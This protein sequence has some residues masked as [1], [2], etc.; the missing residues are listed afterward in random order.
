LAA[1]VTVLP[2]ATE[3]PETV[4]VLSAVKS[5]AL[6]D[7]VSD[8]GNKSGADGVVGGVVSMLTGRLGPG[9][10]TFP[11]GSVTVASID[12]SPSD[13]VGRSQ[14]FAVADATYVHDTVVPS[15]FLAVIFTVS[16]S[17]TVPPDTAGVLS[18]VR[19]SA[20]DDPE[21]DAGNKSGVDGVAGGVVSTEM[22]RPAEGDFT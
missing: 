16:P 11:A 1:I 12:Q 3:P 22:F 15:A 5:S 8:A 21:S 2:F 9:F 20:S 18:D 4:G 6:E 13:I 19:L 7:P 14:L 17:A 10:D